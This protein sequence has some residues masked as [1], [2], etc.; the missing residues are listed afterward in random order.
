[1]ICVPSV[2][3]AVTA[4]TSLQLS[5][6]F[7]RIPDS[8]LF[9]S[10]SGPECLPDEQAAVSNGI[11]CSSIL[12]KHSGDV[13]GLPSRPAVS[14]G[15][16]GW[17]KHQPV[18]PYHFPVLPG[19]PSKRCWLSVLSSLAQDASGPKLVCLAAAYVQIKLPQE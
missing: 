16:P 10:L 1:M 13:N 19:G 14:A 6:L 4:H 11:R 5:S 8:F 15:A 18:T 2:R 9:S 3:I 7:A 17:L 12:N